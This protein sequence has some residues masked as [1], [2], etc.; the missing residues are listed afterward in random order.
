MKKV[1]KRMTL[2][3]MEQVM[4]VLTEEEQSMLIG[5]DANSLFHAMATIGQLYHKQMSVETCRSDYE[6]FVGNDNYLTEGMHFDGAVS[7]MMTEFNVTK[8]DSGAIFSGAPVFDF[9]ESNI[10]FIN[11]DPTNSNDSIIDNVVILKGY[12]PETGICT[13]FDPVSKG[14]YKVTDKKFMDT[15]FMY[16]ISYKE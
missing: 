1:T 15:D 2:F 9:N 7:Y 4:T 16:K 8:L 3:E 11:Y 12:D 10:V 14:T 13:Y 5:G 6:A